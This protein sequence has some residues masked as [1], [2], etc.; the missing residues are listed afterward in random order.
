MS[1]GGRRIKGFFVL[2]TKALGAALPQTELLWPDQRRPVVCQGRE[3][4]PHRRCA[5]L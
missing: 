3:G 4:G 5:V 1:N 2:T